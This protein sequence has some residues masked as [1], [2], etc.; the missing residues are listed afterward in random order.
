[1]PSPEN[2]EQL[3]R[4]I[5]GL[6]M[7]KRDMVRR[8]GFEPSGGLLPLAMVVRRDGAR[9][10]DIAQALRVDLS[11][12]SRQIAALIDAG[13]IERAADPHD[14]RAAVLHATRK[15]RAAL[16]RAHERIVRAYSEALADWSDEDVATLTRLT[17]RLRADYER[18]I[19]AVPE[20]VAA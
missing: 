17:E 6:G 11:V 12:A 7:V 8:T 15:G 4:A 10:K 3:A 16:K 1:M 18:S 9:V 20:E 5:Y 2:L 14:G 13:Y 19:S